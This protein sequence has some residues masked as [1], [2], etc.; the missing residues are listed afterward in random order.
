MVRTIHVL[1]FSILFKYMSRIS[2]KSSTFKATYE[3]HREKTSFLHMEKQ[4]RGFCEADQR[5]CFPYID[6]TIPLLPKAEISS[7]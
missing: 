7:H 6:S 3:P 4:L 2:I 1:S 5:L